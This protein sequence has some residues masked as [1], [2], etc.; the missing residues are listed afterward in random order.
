MT[1]QIVWALID[2]V[3]GLLAAGLLA[4]AAVVLLPESYRGPLPLGVLAV[5]AVVAVAVLRRALGL[6]RVA[7]RG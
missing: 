4:S 2:V 7:P 6:G 3:A 1:R 5:V